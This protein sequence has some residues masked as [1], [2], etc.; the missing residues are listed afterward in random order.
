MHSQAMACRHLLPHH[1]PTLPR[2]PQEL[3]WLVTFAWNRGAVHARFGRCGEAGRYQGWAAAAL[4][5]D[6]HMA[7]QYQVGPHWEASLSA[8]QPR[9]PAG[10]HC[11]QPA[12]ARRATTAVAAACPA[13]PLLPACLLAPQPAPAAC[14]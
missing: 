7:G 4:Q 10:E 8:S 11:W 9:L 5:Y 6:A 3:R 1:P 14:A 12:A 2:V 13:R